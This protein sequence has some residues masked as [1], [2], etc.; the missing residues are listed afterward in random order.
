VVGHQPNAILSAASIAKLAIE[1]LLDVPHGIDVSLLSGA[2]LH[3]LGTYLL[4]A[5]LDPPDVALRVPHAP[6]TIAEEKVRHLGHRHGPGLERPPV[7]GIAVLDVQAEKARRV[8]LPLSR[9]ERHHYRVADPEL[10]VP[11]GAI[12]VGNAGDLL[13]AERLLDE[14]EE[15]G[16]VPRDDSRRDRVI[17]LGHRPNPTVRPGRVVRVRHSKLLSPWFAAALRNELFC[18]EKYNRTEWFVQD[19]IC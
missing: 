6:H 14:V 16:R 10:G 19:V 12:L 18:S 3:L 11:D 17:A 15:P 4:H 5:R 8:R 9:V 1:G 7:D 13:R 2:S